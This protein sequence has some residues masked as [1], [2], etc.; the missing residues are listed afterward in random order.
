MTGRVEIIGGAT[1]VTT[2][3]ALCE[4]PSWEPRY[5][6]KTTQRAGQRHK[7]HIRAAKRGSVLPVHRWLRKQI[8]A[9]RRLAIKHLQW[10]PASGDWIAAERRWIEEYRPT[11]RLLNLTD[12]GEGLTGHEFSPEHRAKIAAALRT[13]GTFAC[14]VCSETFWRKRRDILAGHNRFCSRRCSNARHKGRLPL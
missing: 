11:G 13:G 1:Q 4:Y 5:I 10:V 2:I 12:G 14:E 8:A 3:Y 7:A 6:G 9:G